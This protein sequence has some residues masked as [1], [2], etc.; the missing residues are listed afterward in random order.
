[1]DLL[2]W[3][4]KFILLVNFF[5]TWQ[6]MDLNRTFPRITPLGVTKLAIPFFVWPLGISC[7]ELYSAETA[8]FPG[9]S[10]WGLCCFMGLM[11]RITFIND[12]LNI[13]TGSLFKV[14]TLVDIKSL[15][16]SWAWCLLFLVESNLFHDAVVCISASG[17]Q[18]CASITLTIFYEYILDG[19]SAECGRTKL[20]PINIFDLFHHFFEGDWFLR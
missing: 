1:M 7:S 15:L 3:A 19:F 17:N 18:V 10:Y 6:F 13:Q 12:I 16:K 2:K 8:S 9:R 20:M 4:T 14:L 5:H 11:L